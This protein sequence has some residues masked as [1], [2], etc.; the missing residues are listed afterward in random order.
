MVEEI[1]SLIDQM[2]HLGYTTGE[3]DAW[4]HHVMGDIPIEQLN[5]QDCAELIDHL[6]GYIEFARKKATTNTG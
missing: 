2:V 3:I 4:I 5:E 1:Y 6:N